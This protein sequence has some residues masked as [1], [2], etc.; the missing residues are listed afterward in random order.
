MTALRAGSWVSVALLLASSTVIA[1]CSSSSTA[2]GTVSSSCTASQLSASGGRQGGGFQTA[3][4]DVE[5]K[6]IAPPDCFLGEVPSKISLVRGDGK[7]LDVRY[8][9]GRASGQRLLL[10]PSGVA[11]LII[12]WANWCGPSPGSLRVRISLPNGDGVID[13][14]FD[15]PPDYDYVPGCSNRSQLS[16]LQFLGY[17]GNKPTVPVSAGQPGAPVIS[18]QKHPPPPSPNMVLTISPTSGPAGTTVRIEATGC[19][20]VNGLN[21]AVSF[22]W[23]GLDETDQ[24]ANRNNPNIVVDIPSTLSGTTLTASHTVTEQETAF[25]GGGFTVQC[26]TTIQGAAFAVTK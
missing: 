25:G 15:G 11:D 9:P 3:H 22:N 1:G 14:P 12:S 24:M 4:G 5:L 2:G 10:S 13:A 7:A 20:D 26:G 19:I 6:S 21:H 23:G 8:E 18:S 17:A 16:T